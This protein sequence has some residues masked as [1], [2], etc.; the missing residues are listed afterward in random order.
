VPACETCGRI[1]P[2]DA[3][4]CASCGAELGPSS[5]RETRKVVTVLFADVAGSTAMGEQ[6]DPESLRAVMARY[7]EAARTCLER[8]GATVEKF[9]GDAVMAVFGV[10]TVH[11][12]D[13]LRAARAACELRESVARLNEDLV[14]AFGVSLQVRVGVNTGEVVVGTEER[15]ATGDAVNVAARLEQAAAPGEILLGEETFR[16]ARG[17][18]EVEPVAPVAAKGKAEPIA[19][20][21]L[22]DVR[23]GA[24]PFERRFDAPFVGRAGELDRVRS[25]FEQTIADRRC[26]L[27]TVVGPPGIGKT[28]L[29]RQVSTELRDR[30]VVLTGRCLPYGEGITYWPLREIFGA[31]AAEDELEAAL[32]AGGS[33]EIFLAVRK[34]VERRAREQPL[35]LVVEDIHWAEPTLLDLVEHLTDWTRDAQLLVLCLARPELLDDRPSWGGNRQNAELLTL[36]PLGAEDAAALVTGLAGDSELGDEDRS[37]ILAVAEGNPLFVEQLVAALAEG[38]EARR[39]PATIQ[40]LLASRLETLSPEERDVL[41]RASVVGLEF[42]WDVLAQLAPDRRRPPGSVLF[43]LVRKELI[44]PHEAID[45][46][47]WFRH[48]LIRDAAYDRISKERRADLHERIA[49]WLDGRGGEFDEI[50]GYHLEQAHRCLGDLGPPTQRSRSLGERAAVRLA[51][52]G[53]Q[54]HARGDSTGASNLLERAAT[55]FAP[56]DPRRL[57]LLPTLGRTL[58]EAARMDDAE[59]VL[60][61]AV[62]AAESAGDP[63]L[64]ADARV[65]LIDIRFHRPAQTGVMRDDV[66]RELERAIPVFEL[67]GNE[68]ALARA[69]TLRGKLYFWYGEAETAREFF[70]RAARLAQG[71]GDRAEEAESLQYVLATLHRGRTPVGRALARFDELR[72]RTRMNRRLEAAYLETHAHLEAMQ[73]NFE[74]ARELVR[75]AIAVAVDA[76]LEVLL[77]THTRPSAGF[78]ELL[79]GDAVAAE[80]ELRRACEE[81]ERVGELG[82]LSSITP[83][84]IDAVYAQGRYEEALALTDRWPA[85]RLTAP[86]DVDAQAGWRRV[87]AKALA[88]LG[89]F[90][91]AERLAREAVAILADKDYVNAH[92]DAVA[93]LGEVLLHA[94]RVTDAATAMRE[95][96]RLYELKGNVASANVL[97]GRLAETQIDAL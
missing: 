48:M 25:T 33:E 64:A 20:H 77:E 17:A 28:R 39:V 69:L 74:V 40:A 11:E 56:D 3:R 51:A 88:R 2:D 87:R 53:R 89:R 44:R 94:G 43:G 71:V 73:A 22:L 78:V 4:F 92:A 38:A 14:P 19:A 59:S 79:A 16:L 7:F 67:V 49:D 12:D 10:P 24:E 91:E 9:I 97:R 76:G 36:E 8:H 41:E 70:E 96:L 62:R 65:G 46:T 1:N 45:D 80:A 6:L 75:K 32:A 82:F 61:D 13:A 5:A 42:E 35:A 26:R 95:A 15:L 29:A 34:S 84:L 23:E 93:D 31:A 47:F 54:A 58:R 68:A 60:A 18:L 55:L 30:A 57:E 37:R 21:R 52:S 50:V 72:P 90:E 83:M 66:L 85:Y 86:T 63:G 81:T 27:V